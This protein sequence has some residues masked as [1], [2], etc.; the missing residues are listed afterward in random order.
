M[1]ADRKQQRQQSCCESLCVEKEEPR[2][3]SQ[4]EGPS[5]VTVMAANVT[6]WAVW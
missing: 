5:Q 2:W 4:A 3:V 1:N 6:L